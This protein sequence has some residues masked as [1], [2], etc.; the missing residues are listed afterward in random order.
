MD[1]ELYQRDTLSDLSIDNTARQY[2]LT[3]ATWARIIAVIGFIG[4]AISLLQAVIGGSEVARASSMAY[5]GGVLVS[6][7][8]VAVV[9]VINI[10]LLKFAN[11]T[12]KG[13][14]DVNQLRFNEGVNNLRTYFKIVGILLII[15]VSLVVL[16]VLLFVAGTALR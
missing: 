2:L 9:V 6:M 12:L 1:N 11:N 3:A 8:F 5:T 15:V 7:L 14:D 10:F 16:F 4:A 13:L